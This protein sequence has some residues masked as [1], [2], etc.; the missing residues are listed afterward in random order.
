MANRE[1]D[2][3]DLRPQTI[4]ETLE[5]VLSATIERLIELRD[6]APGFIVLDDETLAG[7]V[8]E[9]QGFEGRA[10]LLMWDAQLAQIREEREAKREANDATADDFSSPVLGETYQ[11]FIDLF[12]LAGLKDRLHAARVRQHQGV[13]AA[14]RY[15]ERCNIT[16]EHRIDTDA[17]TVR[18]TFDR[19]RKIEGDLQNVLDNY[20][21]PAEGGAA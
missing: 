17:A 1:Y 5:S 6:R 3:N 9:L 20:P 11:R 8:V 18:E 2:P 15:L 19:L 12:A 13:E 7:L 16:P 10:S 14:I 21:L 4:N